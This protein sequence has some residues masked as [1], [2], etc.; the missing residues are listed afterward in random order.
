MRTVSAIFRGAHISLRL[1]VV[2][3]RAWSPR[4]LLQSASVSTTGVKRRPRLLG[5]FV[6]SRLQTSILAC[7]DH[8]VPLYSLL[9]QGLRPD[10]TLSCFGRDVEGRLNAPVTVPDR[11]P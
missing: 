2:S 11:L 8:N 3:I 6:P 10:G 5:C 9:L 4:I 7:A 1:L